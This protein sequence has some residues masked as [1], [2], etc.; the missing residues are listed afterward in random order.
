MYQK[1]LPGEDDEDDGTFRSN[2]IIK[3]VDQKPFWSHV[4]GFGYWFC[5]EV[6]WLTYFLQPSKLIFTVFGCV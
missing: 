3:D 1:L 6:N 4:T 5:P 2:K